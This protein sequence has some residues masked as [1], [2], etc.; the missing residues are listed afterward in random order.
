MKKIY[1][2]I[3]EAIATVGYV[4]YVPVAPGT[5]ASALATVIFFL[6]PSFTFTQNSMLWLILFVLGSY[7]AHIFERENNIKDPS[8]IVIDEVLGMSIALFM[9]PKVLWIYCFSFILF[10]IF[11]IIKPFPICLIERYVH[12]GLGVMLDDVLAGLITFCLMFLFFIG[13]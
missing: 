7:C 11:D 8:C 5:V 6:L 12:G 1:V 9:I 3:A 13:K 10:R 4:G 2:R